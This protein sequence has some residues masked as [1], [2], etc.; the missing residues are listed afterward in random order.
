MKTKFVV[1]GIIFL[2]V[3]ILAFL[4]AGINNNGERT[5]V[6]WP[7]GTTFVK[8]T[9]GLY[10]KFFGRTWEYHDVITMDF[11][12]TTASEEATLDQAGIPV[13]YRDG[14]TGTIYGK[15]RFAL[16][17]DEPSMIKAHKAFR[18]NAGL[19][20]KLL[21]SVTEEGMNLTAGL[22]TS[23]EAY[24]TQRAVF[25]QWSEQQISGGKFQ[26]ELD[27]RTE[28]DLVTSKT[29]T[30]K[31]PVIKYGEDGKMIQLDSDLEEYSIE[32]I[33]YQITDWG[34]EPKTLDQIADKRK[35]TMGIITAKANAERAKQDTITA[36]EE[37]K[38]AAMKSRYEQEVKKA[39]AVVVAKQEKEVAEIAA[40]QKVEVAKQTKLEAEQL[41][42]A[43]KE[44][45]QEQTLRGEGDGAYKKIVMEADGALGEKLKAYIEVNR[46]YAEAV[47][48]QKWVP[49]IQFNS[50]SGN[51]SSV[52]GGANQATALIDLL[53]AKTAKEISLDLSV[54]LGSTAS[55]NSN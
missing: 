49:D 18:S 37:G 7:T 29:I 21:K 2:V 46:R 45:K 5:V 43:A 55:S 1:G 32:V 50:G 6:Q 12:K 31:V 22:M 30:K 41:K 54:P 3:I 23:E 53:T 24:D 25:I 14:G 39:K 28:T 44:Y 35:A 42:L 51:G 40:A 16:P 36:E 48:Q 10:F 20:Q 15:A 4:S 27:E 47:E 13:R 38:A 8:F 17:A 9:P 34:F 26:T 33:G 11:D 19:A 52:S